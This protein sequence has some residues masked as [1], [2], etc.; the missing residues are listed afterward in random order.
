MSSFLVFV[1]FCYASFGD[2][3]SLTVLYI[4]GKL[5]YLEFNDNV[6]ILVLASS[7]ISYKSKFEVLIG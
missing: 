7:T 1:S 4:L 5:L 6:L 3:V 2:S